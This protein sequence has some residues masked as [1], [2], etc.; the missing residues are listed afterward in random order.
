[1]NNGLDINEEQFMQL[2]LK[3]RDVMI[4]R[5]LVHIRRQFKEYKINKKVQYIWLVVLSF[6][7]G[8]RKYIP[9]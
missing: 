3:E 7:L 9:L 4:F 6:A 5:N 2:S 8:L 1:M